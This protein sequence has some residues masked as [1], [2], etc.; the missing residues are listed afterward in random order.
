MPRS[1]CWGKSFAHLSARAE[2]EEP[3]G[4]LVMPGHLAKYLQLGL[5]EF[6]IRF[7]ASSRPEGV[8]V[9]PSQSRDQGSELQSQDPQS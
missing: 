3:E 7:R 5:A 2:H 9:S 8:C 4:P 6:S 1:H